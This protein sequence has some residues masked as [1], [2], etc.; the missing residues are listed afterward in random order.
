MIDRYKVCCT[1]KL[2]VDLQ[3]EDNGQMIYFEDH[4]KELK[5]YKCCGNC[6]YCYASYVNTS[7]EV[8][9][10]GRKDTIK[11]NDICDLWE[12]KNE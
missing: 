5:K 12:L 8:S 1:E 2:L 4:E 3:P 10:N 7:C 6:K 9:P 11:A